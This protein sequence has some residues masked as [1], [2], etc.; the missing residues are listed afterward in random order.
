MNQA[1]TQL[2][3]IIAA[4]RAAHPESRAVRTFTLAASSGTV[5]RAQCIFCRTIIA[6]C[7]AS[8]PTTKAFVAACR[9]HKCEARAKYEQEVS[10]G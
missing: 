1:M 2:P 9:D 4:Y 5:K 8:W 7:S 6:T 10:R 3:P